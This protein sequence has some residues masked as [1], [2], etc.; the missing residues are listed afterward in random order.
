MAV[1]IPLVP[2]FADGD[3]SLDKLNALSAAVSFL[4]DDD[5]RPTLHIYNQNTALTLTASTWTTLTGAKVAYDSDG[6]MGGV[7]TFAPVIQTPG[8]YRFEGCVP[9]GAAG[10]VTRASFLVT[11]GANNPNW[12]TGTTIRFALRGMS[13]VT[14]LAA[15]TTLTPTGMAPL[16][17]FPGD[18]VALQAWCSTSV[19]ITLNTNAS[20]IQG[21]FVPNMTGYYIVPGGTGGTG[22]SGASNMLDEGGSAILDEAGNVITDESGV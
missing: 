15:D 7:I 20:Y 6:M 11:T 22:S 17:L 21:R 18:V 19:S 5:V 1:T 14:G 8:Y 9:L 2:V 13:G 4:A 16:L 10:S 3:S 12:N